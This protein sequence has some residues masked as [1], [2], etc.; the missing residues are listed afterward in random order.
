MKQ[1]KLIVWEIQHLALTEPQDP[2]N[3]KLTNK[4]ITFQ[5]S[6][7]QQRPATIPRVH[8][9]IIGVS[10]LFK[11]CT[12]TYTHTHKHTHTH[13][14]KYKYTQ[15]RARAHTH[16]RAR[17]CTHTHTNTHTHTYTYTHIHTHIHT[18]THK[19]HVMYILTKR[20]LNVWQE[21]QDRISSD[22]LI[23]L[24]HILLMSTRKYAME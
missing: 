23:S 8:P 11:D 5:Y 10:L 18:H 6:I 1:E 15:A 19:H 2:I 9:L 22:T 17:A 14:H 20:Q 16:A 7:N 4:P 21:K 13:T 3:Y 24:K 12:H